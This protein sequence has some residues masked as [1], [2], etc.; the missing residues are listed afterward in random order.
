[1]LI[2]QFSSFAILLASTL[3]F[4]IKQRTINIYIRWILI[5]YLVL[6]G[7]TLLIYFFH[8]FPTNIVFFPFLQ[9]INILFLTELY[10]SIIPTLSKKIKY[11]IWTSAVL[12]FTIY[13]LFFI[14]EPFIQYY[15]NVLGN[16]FIVLLSFWYFIEIITKNSNQTGFLKLNFTIFFY[17]SIEILIALTLRFLVNADIK[18]VGPIWIFRAVLIQLYY[19]SL[20]HFGW[21]TGKIKE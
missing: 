18:W 3:F 6:E 17:F 11:S 5:N 8:T 19:L 4:L 14:N 12:F 1:M 2:L 10:S 15:S 13:Y 20:I 21:K 16:I 9:L 7:N